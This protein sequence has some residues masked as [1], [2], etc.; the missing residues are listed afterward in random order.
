MSP[1][2]N[3][4]CV[5]MFLAGSLLASAILHLRMLGLL[6]MI[7]RL[8]PEN[9]LHK[10]ARHTLLSASSTSSSRSWFIA[11]RLLSQRY[12]L[13]DP[14]LV[15][16]SPPTVYQWKT[17]T[18]SKVI[19]WHEKKFRAEAE[20]LPSLQYFKPQFMSLSAPHPIWTSAGSPYEVSKAVIAA[21]M[22]SGR[23]RTDRL[24]RHWTYDNPDGLCRLPGCS[25]QE[26]NLQHILLT[27]PALFES[28][29]KMISLWSSYMVSRTNLLPVVNKYT[30]E[31]PLLQ[32][33][34][35]LDPSALPL[36]ISTERS[37][38]G[39]LQ[40]CLYL[41]RTWCF[42]VHVMRSK[43]MKQLNIK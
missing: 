14:I 15:L 41:G 17:L 23:Y 24:S 35:L 8:G 43:L 31:E 13:P 18:K 32:I 5:F 28:R 34:L 27:C 42:S 9:I 30:I 40:Q 36:V 6:A 22:M 39:T 20:L 4:T 3:P 25:D 12:D 16:Q 2:L 19:D 21:R 37:Y 7:A 38:P 11:I 10:H 29:C 26:G 33:Q 1:P